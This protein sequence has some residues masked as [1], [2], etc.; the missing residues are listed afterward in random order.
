[1]CV[2]MI[3]LGVFMPSGR[4]L[5]DLLQTALALSIAG[6]VNLP[7]L[8]WHNIIILM[9]KLI[10]YGCKTAIMQPNNT[11]VLAS[12]LYYLISRLLRFC[13]VLLS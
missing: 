12:I 6:E 4:H 13:E 2:H 8:A 7:V 1:V 9:N 3:Y 11:N 5:I 10:K